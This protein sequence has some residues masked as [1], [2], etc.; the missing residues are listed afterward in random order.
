MLP[1]LERLCKGA[2]NYCFVSCSISNLR[3]KISA[4]FWLGWRN[5]IYL[6]LWSRRHCLARSPALGE[7]Q[8]Q[9]LWGNIASAFLTHFY[10]SVNLKGTSVCVQ[11]TFSDA[12]KKKL[13]SL[14]LAGTE[15]SYQIYFSWALSLWELAALPEEVLEM[16][17]QEAF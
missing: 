13:C 12:V 10:I 15:P 16:P 11:E 1:A 7:C 5:S 3:K 17:S 9:C 2:I 14:R 4:C 6:G 8:A